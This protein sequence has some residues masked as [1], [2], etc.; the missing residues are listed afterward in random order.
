MTPQ[1]TALEQ[2]VIVL[3][4]AKGMIDEIVNYEIFM[5]P[6]RVTDIQLVPKTRTHARLFNVLLVDFLSRPNASVFGLP[7]PPENAPRSERSYLFY[8]KEISRNPKLNPRGGDTIQQPVQAF[9]DWL[10]AECFVEKVY[11]SSIDVETDVRIKRVTF[12]EICGNISKHSFARLSQMV[13]LIC[14]VLEDNNVTIDIEQGYLAIPDFY[15]WFHVNVLS[16]HLSAIAEFLNNIRWGIYEY[17]QPEFQRSYTQDDPRSIYYRFDP[18]QDCITPMATSMYWELMNSVRAK[19]YMPRF[20]V[21][22][23][24][25]RRY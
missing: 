8:L 2:E 21:T 9:L 25:K 20:E 7:Q 4:A 19:P 14:R 1:F 24:L 16:Y 22:P 15:E 12:I 3:N 10:E 6:E 5:K 17:L 11:L 18:P 23:Y 13:R